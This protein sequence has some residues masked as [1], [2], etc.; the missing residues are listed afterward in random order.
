M[1]TENTTIEKKETAQEYADR[2]GNDSQCNGDV[3]A[4]LSRVITNLC[5]IPYEQSW[6]DV[7]ENKIVHVF[8]KRD[9]TN[10]RRKL[11]CIYVSQNYE[12]L[13]VDEVVICYSD[14]DKTYKKGK[15]IAVIIIKIA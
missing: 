12:T 5:N 9:K 2:I 8:E 1:K 11:G 13:K 10:T 14:V 7:K 15:L 4:D 3:F 6:R